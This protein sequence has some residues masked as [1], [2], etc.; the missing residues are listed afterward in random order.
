M[1]D[2]KNQSNQ[3]IEPKIA[4][5]ITKSGIYRVQP[6]KAEYSKFGEYEG[7]RVVFSVELGYA[8]NCYQNKMIFYSKEKDAIFKE[9]VAY[10]L[11]HISPDLSTKK[12]SVKTV[13]EYIDL[14]SVDIN[15]YLK[16]RRDA[17]NPIMLSGKILK[18]KNKD[19]A[20]FE[21][22]A[23]KSGDFRKS[24]LAQLDD[25]KSQWF[26]N[27]ELQNCEMPFELNA[28]KGKSSYSEPIA[29][30]EPTVF[31]AFNQAEVVDDLPF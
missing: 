30:P 13:K 7:M 18:F 24:Y 8:Y 2:Q 15:A 21:E 23:P 22:Y 31:D 10:M 28:G 20:D 12:Y 27:W 19:F 1:S 9:E 14:L 26:T 5:R 6:I 25:Y 17:K 29:E 11:K 3:S 16:E 4:V